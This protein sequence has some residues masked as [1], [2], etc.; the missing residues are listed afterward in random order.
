MIMKSR[1]IRKK[2]HIVYNDM[3]KK[4]GKYGVK[5]FYREFSLETD[6]KTLRANFKIMNSN[7][8]LQI[9]YRMSTNK[10]LLLLEN[11]YSLDKMHTGRVPY[12]VSEA[13]IEEILYIIP[14]IVEMCVKYDKAVFVL[15]TNYKTIQDYDLSYVDVNSVVYNN[16]DSFNNR[17]KRYIEHIKDSLDKIEF[18]S[19]YNVVLIKYHK[20]DYSHK[21]TY[22]DELDW[23]DNYRF[24]IYVNKVQEDI[25]EILNDIFLDYTFNVDYR[26]VTSN[27]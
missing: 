8:F 1:T 23:F 22:D 14:N 2:L 17:L 25:C 16:S 10:Y 18:I 21:N 11:L 12:S 6:N 9:V 15:S 19:D 26:I 27:R 5:P 24:D 4:F 7:C 13:T 3:V 20:V